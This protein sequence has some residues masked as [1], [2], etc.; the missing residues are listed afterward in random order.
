MPADK[1]DY[2]SR[3]LYVE[4]LLSGQEWRTV[5]AEIEQ[6]Y[7]PREIETESKERVD[8]Y[9][10]KFKGKS[11]M[12]VLSRTNEQVLH[13]VFGDN[14]GPAWVGQTVTLQPRMVMSFGSLEPAIRTIPPNGTPL[15]RKVLERLGAKL[16]YGA[17]YEI[18]KGKV[19]QK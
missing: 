12:L 13:V 4:D 14:P 1:M 15:R 9:V 18:R 17:E 6:V 8:K 3:F 16:V 7:E 10:L 19:V 5:T 2:G 11:K